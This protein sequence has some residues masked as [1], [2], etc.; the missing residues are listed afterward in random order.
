MFSWII[1]IK[2]PCLI[3]WTQ[4]FIWDKVFLALDRTKG[5]FFIKPAKCNLIS[6]YIAWYKVRIFTQKIKQFLILWD[7]FHL[8]RKEVMVF[9]KGQQV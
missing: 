7:A 3:L 8:G 6:K 2:L 5:I 4:K 9:M 1:Y